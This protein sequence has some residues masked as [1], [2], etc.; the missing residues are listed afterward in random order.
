MKAFLSYSLNDSEQ[1]VLSIL[2]RK[3]NEQ[4]FVVSSSYDHN[5]SL[6]RFEQ[7][8]QINSS[9][10][11][12][13]V[14]TET[15]REHERVFEEWNT[16]VKLKVPA[17]LLV[18]KRVPVHRPYDTNPNIIRFDKNNPSPSIELVKKQFDEAQQE[19]ATVTTAAWAL[20]G[21][22]VLALIALLSDSGKK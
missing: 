3:L 1:Y 11:F 6:V 21:L 4:G 17:L 14:M 15:T 7:F 13:G 16:A 8:N 12:I 18:E 2:V 10:L 19:K 5:Y 22:A 9:N 20:G